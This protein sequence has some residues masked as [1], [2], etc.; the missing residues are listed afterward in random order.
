MDFARSDLLN[1]DDDEDEGDSIELEDST[2]LAHQAAGTGNMALL[3]DAVN[4]DPS[5]LES[6]DDKGLT[7]LSQAVLGKKQEML[8]ILLKMG[9]NIN[10]QDAIGRTPLC[11]AAYEGWY[12]GAVCLLRHGAKQTVADKS[13]RLPIHAATCAKESRTLSALLQSLSVD[14]V[15]EPDNEGMTA[16]HWAAFHNRP[17]HIQLL[18]LR[19]GDIYRT[20]IDEK[21]P[22]H[23]ASQNGCLVCCS[24]MAKC[25][26]GGA[27]LINAAEATGKTCV[28]LAAAAGYHEILLEFAQLPHADFEALDPDE[29]TPLHWAAVKGHLNCVKVLLDLGVCFNPVDLDGGTPLQ[30]S[31]QAGKDNVMKFLQEMERKLEQ[32][33]HKGDEGENR[34]GRVADAGDERTSESSREGT[35]DGTKKKRFGFFTSWLDKRRNAK[36]RS[37]S[38]EK[39]QNSVQEDLGVQG[40]SQEEHTMDKSNS[41][42]QAAEGAVGFDAMSG[43]SSQT[44]DGVATAGTP[45][46]GMNSGIPV[47]NKTGTQVHRRTDHDTQ[48][49]GTDEQML[50]RNVGGNLHHALSEPYISD[51]CPSSPMKSGG[52]LDSLSLSPSMDQAPITYTSTVLHNHKQDSLNTESG[53]KTGAARPGETGSALLV[54]PFYRDLPNAEVLQRQAKEILEAQNRVGA[55]SNLQQLKAG[56]SGGRTLSSLDGHSAVALRPNSPKLAPII[57]KPRIPESFAGGSATVAAGSNKQRSSSL[58]VETWDNYWREIKDTNFRQRPDVLEPIQHTLVEKSKKKRKKKPQKPPNVL[59][60]QGPFDIENRAT[61]ASAKHQELIS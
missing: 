30:Y 32:G 2:L 56:G 6:C 4:R 42:D 45:K 8:K 47:N 38:W 13:G 21:T 23:W 39:K 36:L 14:E 44:E 29:R 27:P 20:D 55:T 57:T 25:H 50:Q 40:V 3:M 46:D 28:H 24:V 18:M 61:G 5:V 35:K 10:T 60:E 19:G 49:A 48:L 59:M 17:E 53:A 33:N 11:L 15:N 7:P 52:F 54:K 9:A 1:M 22:L 34:G 51:L 41:E 37:G 31:V 26:S 43:D 58:T 12:E 16:L